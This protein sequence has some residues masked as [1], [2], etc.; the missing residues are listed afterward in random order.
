MQ[1]PMGEM[2]AGQFLMLPFGDIVI[3]KWDLAK[4]TGQETSLDAN[5][6]EACFNV[7]S[8]GI[9][10]GREIGFFGPEVEIAANS[11]I[12]DKLLG[13]SGRQP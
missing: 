12:Q 11:S 13:L 10:Q 4:A 6:A 1:S 2:P 5:L 7:M 3:H 8:A 9:A